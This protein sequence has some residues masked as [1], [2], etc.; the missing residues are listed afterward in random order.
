MRTSLVLVH[1]LLSHAQH[2]CR[3]RRHC[4]DAREPSP[5]RD[6]PVEESLRLFSDMRRGLLDEGAATLRCPTPRLLAPP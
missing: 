6:R 1:V 4:R 5:W 3:V 2:P